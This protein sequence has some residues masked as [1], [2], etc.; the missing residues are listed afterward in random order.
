M[1]N[2]EVP[3][4]I[5]DSEFIDTDN[6]KS[7]L[8]QELSRL[9]NSSSVPDDVK[10]SLRLMDEVQKLVAQNTGGSDVSK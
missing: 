1:N 4:R 8:F 5:E 10:Q 7:R 3:I 9:M 6:I 2:K